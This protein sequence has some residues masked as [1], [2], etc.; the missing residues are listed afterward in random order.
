MTTHTQFLGVS[1]LRISTDDGRVVM[2]D[3]FLDA[4]MVSPLKVAHLDRG[5]LIL[6]THAAFDHLGDAEAIA[7]KTEAPVVCGWDVRAY[8]MARGVPGRQVRAAVW[9]L[10]VDIAGFR[11][12]PVESHHWSQLTLPNGSL[13]SGVPMGFVLS[14]EPGVCI[15]HHGDTALFSD[16]KLM[17]ELYQPKAVIL[18][19]GETFD[20][21]GPEG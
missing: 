7:K 3:P 15:Y 18:R 10:E 12:R 19:P 9:G 20:Y 8:L 2:M 11:V 13:I 1:A 4:N 5:D 6:I 16:L 14:A 17:G 21:G